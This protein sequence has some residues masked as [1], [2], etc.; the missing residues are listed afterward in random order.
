MGQ[1]VSDCKA[2]KPGD[3]TA[4]TVKVD[5]NALADPAEG[6]DGVEA[7]RAEQG[8]ALATEQHDDA[9]QAGQSAEKAE[10]LARQQEEEMRFEQERLEME[11]LEMERLA[12]EQARR[13]AEEEERRR[14]EEE[15]RR[16]HEEERRKAEVLAE[17]LAQEERERAAEAERL[18]HEKLRAEEARVAAE[19]E[20]KEIEAAQ[21]AVEDFL[22]TRGFRQLSLPRKAF[23]GATMYPLHVAVEEN[24]ASMVQ[25]MVRCGAD[26]QQKNSAKKT[27]LEL[28]EK[29]NKG[30]S[31]EVI[32]STLRGGAA[33]KGGA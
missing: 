5:F 18:H 23:C 12:A 8:G 19:K 33:L 26:P 10:E 32:V 28:A 4:D 6:P 21:R 16:Q 31:H 1:S 7:R 22:K 29:C 15:E 13:E 9:E 24:D 17:T 3:P 27:P 25:A 20:R 2:C 11:R 14:A 30:G